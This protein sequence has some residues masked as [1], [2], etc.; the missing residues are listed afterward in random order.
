MTH[1]CNYKTF[2]VS[3]IYIHTEYAHRWKCVSQLYNTK[4]LGYFPN[5]KAIHMNILLYSKMLQTDFMKH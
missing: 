1:S 3:G 2:N 4:T 5:A